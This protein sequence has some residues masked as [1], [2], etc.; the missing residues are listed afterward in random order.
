MLSLK[1]CHR[2]YKPAQRHDRVLDRVEVTLPG[3]DEKGGTGSQYTDELRHREV[4]KS[5]ADW[6]LKSDY[7]QYLELVLGIDQC[8][9]ELLA[10]LEETGQLQ[11]TVVMFTSDNGYMYGEHGL[12][13]KSK[14][15]DPSLRVPLLVRYPKEIS[16]G[17]R[18]RRL[19]VNA[20]LAPTLLTL[21]S[22]PVPESYRG[23]SLTQVW[24]KPASTWRTNT[25]HYSPLQG[26][27]KIPKEFA[28]RTERWK[29]M[30]LRSG[31]RTEEMLFDLDQDPGEFQNLAGTEGHAQDLQTLRDQFADAAERLELPNLWREVLP[32]RASNEQE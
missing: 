23:R 8:V 3:H 9:G 26:D 10:V 1:N 30:L 21:A 16:A 4:S 11:Q 31:R 27:Q 13:R 28:L 14:T 32:S 5:R 29:Y 18:T 20:D 2:P 25:F 7:R 24:R 19:V 6:I 22:I 15:Y 12:F 17:Q